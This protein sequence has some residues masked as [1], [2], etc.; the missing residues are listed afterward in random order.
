MRIIATDLDGTL[1]NELGEVSVENAYAIR[2]A[3]ERGIEVVIVTGRP[4]NS[5]RKTLQPFEL[6]CPIIC[7]NGAEIHSVEGEIVKDVPLH[8]I[9]CQKIK[10]TCQSENIY[11][12]FFTNHGVYSDNREG[13]VQVMI[14]IM[15]TVNPDFNKEEIRERAD[16]RFQNEQFQFIKNYDDLFSIENLK[17][18]KMLAFSHEKEKLDRIYK[19]LE[20]EPNLTVTSSARGNLEFN[21][22][23]AQKGIALRFFAESRGIEMK[24]VMAVGDNYNDITMLQMAG[25]GVAMGNAEDEIKKVCS[26]TTK[27]N[28]ENGVAYAIQEV[29]KEGSE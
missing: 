20:N 6:K 7:L 10:S 11:F 17:I 26:Y 12:E 22:P 9:Q 2:N 5:A 14:D 16:K 28:N 27:T 1:L 21:H 15:T 29:L 24:E 19:Q 18:Y 3:K 23:V 4:Y 25:R 13:Y 8:T